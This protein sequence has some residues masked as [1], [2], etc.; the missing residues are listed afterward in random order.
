MRAA[1]H[2]FVNVY[3]DMIPAIF[4][5][6]MAVITYRTLVSGEDVKQVTLSNIPLAITWP[7]SFPVVG[8]AAAYSAYSGQT[9]NFN[10]HIK[11]KDGYVCH[12]Q[13]NSL[14]LN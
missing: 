9:V 6:T 2:K 14:V 8:A 3:V 5:T 10:A 13:N 4:G 7:I 11:I 1:L 12:I